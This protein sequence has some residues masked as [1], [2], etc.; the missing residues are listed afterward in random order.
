MGSI[1]EVGNW[2]TYECK[3]TWTEGHVWVSQDLYVTSNSYFLYKYVVKNSDEEGDMTWEN[4][5]DRI[6]DLA[7]LPDLTPGTNLKT[8]EIFDEWES[9]R[10]NF[11]MMH[12]SQEQVFISGS[13]DELGDW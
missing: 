1:P 13:R 9:F 8:V 6:A 4:G 5:F 3:M 2:Q 10:I 7:V 11:K 12:S